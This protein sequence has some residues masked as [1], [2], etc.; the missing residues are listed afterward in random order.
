VS[1]KAVIVFAA[2]TASERGS[3]FGLLLEEGAT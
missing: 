3:L 2:C 1:P